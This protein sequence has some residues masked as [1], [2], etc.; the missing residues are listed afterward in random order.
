MS[1]IKLLLLGPLVVIC[2]ACGGC[3]GDSAP[4]IIHPTNPPDPGSNTQIT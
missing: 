1:L 3:G 4:V 2:I